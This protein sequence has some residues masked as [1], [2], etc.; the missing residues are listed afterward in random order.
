MSFSLNR[1]ELIGRLGQD[2]EMRFTPEGQAVT[3][4]SLATDRPVKAGAQPETDWHQI[5]CWRKLAEFAGQYL[6]KGRLVFVAGRLTY[7][8][9]EGKDG[10]KHYRT[11]IVASEVVLLDRRPESDAQPSARAE[12]D[13]PF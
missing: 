9:W 5:V 10:L 4:F 12:D 8:S 6:S 7:R 11:E 13:L 1:A 3:K 2:P